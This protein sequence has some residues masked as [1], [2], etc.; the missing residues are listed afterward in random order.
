M[1]TYRSKTSGTASKAE[2]RGH[3]RREVLKMAGAGALAAL[4]AP[5]I[6]SSR[7]RAQSQQIVMP[8]SGGSFMDAWQNEIITPF[9]EETGI[10]VQMVSGNMKAHAMNLLSSR[11]QPPFDLFL[12]N[13]DD[14]VQL[15]DDDRMLPLTP[16]VVPSIE[17][18]HDKFKDQWDGHG[19]MFDYFSIGFG[20]STEQIENA[21]AS[22]A[23]FVDRTVA[24]DFGSTVFFNSLTGGVRGPEVMLTLG[25]ALS[26]E[27]NNIDA[28]F[29]AV[30]R[31][32]PNIFKF[33]SAINEPVV[34]LLN[35]EGSIGP[36]WDGRTYIAHDESD[37]LIQF[38]K[39]SEGLASNG[40]AIGVVR[41][42]NEEAAFI[43]AEYSLSAPVQKRFCESMFYGSPNSK[44]VY[45][46]ELQDRIPT[47]DE[48]SVPD[49]RFIAENLG[50][51]I[52][53]WNAEI[54]I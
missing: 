41:G 13:G 32:K 15:L 10:S 45:S 39:P 28:A 11:G 25:R 47:P 8:M 7:V 37:G 18:I 19:S 27:E 16:D 36:G 20:Y 34:M 6:G 42:G 21:P 30:Q 52:D 49:E 31:M 4:A 51:W 3:G 12:G 40:P 54:A 43:L 46:E 33:F 38:V 22:W 14:F 2:K 44:V 5:Y 29:D 35:G 1:R 26:G 50:A 24:G 17:D 23:E 9:T 48:I 53:R